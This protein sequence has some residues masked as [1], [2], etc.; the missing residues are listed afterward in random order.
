MN[1]RRDPNG[2]DAA[3]TATATGIASAMSWDVAC[4]AFDEERRCAGAGPRNHGVAVIQADA[5]LWNRSV[6]PQ[7]CDPALQDRSS[8]DP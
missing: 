2:Y 5:D 7:E 1:S 6:D 8:A 3:G 4:P